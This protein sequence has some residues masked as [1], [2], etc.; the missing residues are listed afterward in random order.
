MEGDAT[1]RITQVLKSLSRDV[2]TLKG[3]SAA[4]EVLSN[5]EKE[6]V[7]ET[8]VAATN[9]FGDALQFLR[10]EEHFAR[11]QSSGKCESISAE[12][13]VRMKSINK[14]KTLG[15]DPW[16]RLKEIFDITSHDIDESV[17]AV[18]KAAA[19]SHHGNKSNDMTWLYS[20]MSLNPRSW[21]DQATLPCIM[22]P[23]SRSS[24]FFDRDD[25]I[26]E[27]EKHFDERSSQA[28][29]SIAL[30]GMAGVGKTHV[31]VKYAQAQFTKRSVSAVLWVEAESKMKVKQSFTDIAARLRL[32]GYVAHNHDDNRLLVLTWLQQTSL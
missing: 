1:R 26:D 10:D 31:A 12:A 18:E 21:K 6:A 17:K 13:V 19:M 20:M 16:K 29:R 4:Q 11:S 28:F 30:Y 9:F 5:K 14:S 2:E 7:F 23:P 8:F 24:R 22:L 25:V 27:I 32:P 15:Q 3:Y